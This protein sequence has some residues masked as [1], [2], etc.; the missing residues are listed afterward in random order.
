MDEPNVYEQSAPNQSGP[1]V[2]NEANMLE[3]S[4]RDP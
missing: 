2:F 4:V 3:F 1:D